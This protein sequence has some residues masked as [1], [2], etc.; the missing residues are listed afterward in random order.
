MACILAALFW[1]GPAAALTDAEFLSLCAGERGRVS[2]LALKKALA[3]GANVN[4]T[5]PRGLT[6]LMAFVSTHREADRETLPG[7]K[8]LLAAGPDLEARSEEGGTALGYALLNQAGPRVIAAL[9]AAGAEVRAPIG[10]QGGLP[11]LL[12]AAGLEPDPL[13]SALL[14]A[15]GAGRELGPELQAQADRQPEVLRLLTG[16][17]EADGEEGLPLFTKAPPDQGLRDRLKELDARFRPPRDAEETWLDYLQWQ[18]DLPLNVAARREVLGRTEAEAW[19]DEYAFRL[20]QADPGPEPGRG[21]RDRIILPGPRPSGPALAAL[22]AAD[23]QVVVLV[24]AENLL[25][26]FETVSGRE[27]WRRR[28]SGPT[29]VLPAGRL[30]MAATAWGGG[31]GEAVVL[32]PLTGAVLLT[33]PDL[34]D[35][36]WI[37]DPGR[38]ALIISTDFSLDIF[39]LS[40]WKNRHWS[41]R[42]LL[43]SQGWD[44]A[45]PSARARQNDI[46]AEYGERLDDEGRF[47]HPGGTLFQPAPAPGRAMLDRARDSLAARGYGGELVPLAVEKKNHPSFVLGPA[48]PETCGPEE[49]AVP[50]VLVNPARNRLD[51]LTVPEPAGERFLTRADLAASGPDPG[52]RFSPDGAI[53]AVSENTGA[54]HFFAARNQ[55]RHLGGFPPQ[56]R[57]AKGG[58][59]DPPIRDLKL[60]ALLTDDQHPLALFHYPAGDLC[61]LAEADP[62]GTL[63]PRPLEPGAGIGLTAWAA[64]PAGHWA[65]GLSDGGLWLF[66]PD[67]PAPTLLAAPP[68]PA[69]SALA[70]S[71]DGRTLAAASGRNIQL[72]RAGG[73]LRLPLTGEI[74]HL[75]LDQGGRWLWAGLTFQAGRRSAAGRP[76]LALIDLNAPGQPLYHMTEGPVLALRPDQGRAL[77]LVEALQAEGALSPGAADRWPAGRTDLW[78]FDRWRPPGPEG[79]SLSHPDRLFAG[80]APTEIFH[81]QKAPDRPYVS[82]GRE[83]PA[84]RRPERFKADGRQRRLNPASLDPDHRLA[85][86]PELDGGSFY[87]FNLAT[88]REIIRGRS[89]DPEGLLGAAFLRDPSRLLT[90]GRGGLVRLWSLSAPEPRLLLTWA[91]AEGGRWAVVTPEGFFDADLPAESDHILRSAGRGPARPLSRFVAD[92]YRPGLSQGP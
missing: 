49:A 48:C 17:L 32:E 66:S 88:G 43:D 76:A 71:G 37:V 74:A 84:D 55:G 24:Y 57:L 35:P 67:R 81:Q 4:F 45:R 75:A 92:Y 53:L 30:I 40:S 69:W 54:I 47:I 34:D 11:P 6:P 25:V 78:R 63:R 52:L 15:G 65:A 5:G 77:A 28:P 58:S 26:A 33:L 7:L 51:A 70:F 38:R 39:D 9:L 20:A 13:V 10:P 83:K 8:V 27:L 14:W 21:S 31:L 87:I 62:G 59:D 16:A 3:E 89:G 82:L 36:K 64:T 18:I 41:W 68:A 50:L 72:F 1:A 2:P 73:T 22:V 56:A 86:F 60:L 79:L 12:L 90:F 85:V 61:L 44:E 91:F 46:L 23:R 80:L 29:Q 42:D 19:L